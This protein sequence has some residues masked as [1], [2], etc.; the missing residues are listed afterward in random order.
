MKLLFLNL[1]ISI[2][3]ISFS[4]GADEKRTCP[5]HPESYCKTAPKDSTVYRDCCPQ[6]EASH[7]NFGQNNPDTVAGMNGKGAC[8]CGKCTN[9]DNRIGGK[10]EPNLKGSKGQ[11]RQVGNKDY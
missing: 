4:V 5:P 3:L 9:S 2:T 7:S 6:N 8:S 10:G 11:T 1:C